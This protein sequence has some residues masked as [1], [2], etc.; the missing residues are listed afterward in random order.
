MKRDFDACV[1]SNRADRIDARA[2]MRRTR[3]LGTPHFH[4]KRLCGLTT[5]APALRFP[6]I[7]PS[8]R[9]MPQINIL[10]LTRLSAEDRAR[11]E[12]VDPVGP[13]DRCRRLVRRR[14][15]RDLAGL[16]RGAL[17]GAGRHRP[18]NPRGTRPSAR[19]GG[20]HPRR[21]AIPARPAC[22]VA[23]AEMVSSAAR[24]ARAICFAAICGAAT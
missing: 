15:S 18:G 1:S 3:S 20:H 13:A 22:P 5:G 2:S 10:T 11:I 12:A 14:V 9:S 17:S 21:L 7:R 4:G 19:R 23:A 6:S 8:E 16:Y 24:R